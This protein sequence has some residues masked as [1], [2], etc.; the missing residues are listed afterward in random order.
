MYEVHGMKEIKHKGKLTANDMVWEL[1]GNR[2]PLLET[3]TTALREIRSL[4][5]F[6]S[7]FTK[8]KLDPDG[9]MRSSYDPSG[10]ETYRWSSKKNAFDRGANLQNIPEG[11]DLD[12]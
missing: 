12:E 8:A 2:E 11:V 6:F 10:T 1:I 4:G 5:V 7:T 3:I 9:M